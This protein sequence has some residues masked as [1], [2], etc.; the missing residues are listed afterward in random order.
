[1]HL[2]AEAIGFRVRWLPPASR[3]IG[4]LV[5]DDTRGVVLFVPR[6]VGP[7]EFTTLVR[8]RPGRYRLAAIDARYQLLREVPVAH[9]VVTPAMVAAHR[10]AQSLTD[11]SSAATN[12][13]AP[14]AAT[15]QGE[16]LMLELVHLLKSALTEPRT[17][18]V[19]V[20]LIGLLRSAMS[21]HSTAL[22]DALAVVKAQ[23]TESARHVSEL[24]RASA[25]VVTAAD[26]AGI[27]R[28]DPLP[29]DLRPR[30]PVP[31]HR[32]AGVHVARSSYVYGRFHFR[33]S[34][35]GASQVD[36][37]DHRDLRAVLGSRL[38]ASPAHSSG[39]L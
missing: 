38:G 27:S 7:E 8:Y 32:G 18:L 26:G 19:L 23:A 36:A 31:R 1:M 9:F 34:P 25:T 11:T 4:E 21:G 16:S 35:V 24:V 29:A 28:R 22:S 5:V 3:G 10:A 14:S 33:T 37:G 15:P 6:G 13:V 39:F 30:Q 2:P 17:D 12:I 20:E